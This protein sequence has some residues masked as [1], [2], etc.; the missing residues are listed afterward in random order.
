MNVNWMR[1]DQ[2]SS[3]IWVGGTYDGEKMGRINK[4]QMVG[5]KRPTDAYGKRTKEGER[6]EWD[7]L[8]GISI[9]FMEEHDLFHEGIGNKH[10]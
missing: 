5:W 7:P 8:D 10:H 1:K 2:K 6:M 9:T 3:V 4:G